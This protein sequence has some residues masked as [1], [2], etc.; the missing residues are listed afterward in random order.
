LNKNLGKYV[1]F[2]SEQEYK[3]YIEDYISFA[4]KGIFSFDKTV[5]T[6]Y[7][8]EHYHLVAS[9]SKILNL[10]QLPDNIIQLLNRTQ[11]KSIISE[12]ET[13]FAREIE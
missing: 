4:R 6:N 1:K 12:T 2:R 5:L 13:V 10:N 8:D 9:P 7:S 3:N 11:F